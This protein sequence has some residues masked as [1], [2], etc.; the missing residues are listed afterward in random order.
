MP[1]DKFGNEIRQRTSTA[2]SDE[3]ISL[4]FANNTYIRLDGESDITGNLNMALR[5]IENLGDPTNPKD[6]TSK[7][8]V[9]NTKGTGVIGEV[10]DETATLKG[11][12]DFE[13][14]YR[15]KNLPVP[16]EQ[17]DA[18]NREYVD[19]V[20]IN[21][22]FDFVDNKYQ[23]KDDLDLQGNK[24][25]N[26]CSPF[27][28]GD[29]ATKGYLDT[30]SVAFLKVDQGIYEAKA[31]INLNNIYTV[32]NAKAPIEDGHITDKKYVDDQIKLISVFKKRN[33]GYEARNNLYMR[34][35][36][37]LGLR[38]PIQ[39]G[40]AANKQY[41]DNIYK[42]LVNQYIDDDDNLIP[43]KNVNMEGNQV[44]NLPDP[45][46]DQDAV[47]KK[48]VD[49]LQTQHV[50][51]KGNIKFGR[52]VNLDNKRI[53]A[54]KEPSKPNEGANK[55]YVDDTITKRIQEEKDNFLPQDPATKNYVDE[56]IRGIAAGDVLVSKEGVFIKE[57]GHYR[58]TAPLDID[59]QK[60]TNVAD[61]VDEKDAV[62]RK[63][64]DDTFKELTLKQG[65]IR[66]NGG[67]NLVD[68][69]I[70]MNFNNIRNLGTPKDNSDAVPRSFVENSIK[71][72]DEK[73]KKLKERIN[74]ER[75]SINMNYK[76]LLNLQKPTEKYDAA[77]KD[78]VD[79][80]VKE[81]IQFNFGELNQLVSV[82]ASC[83]EHLKIDDYPF[84]FGGPILNGKLN[85]L[86]KYNGF[87][88][89]ADGLL[90]HVSIISTGLVLNIPPNTISASSLN[91][92][93]KEI[94]KIY[95]YDAKRI[96]LFSVI[97]ISDLFADEIIGSVFVII[98]TH[99]NGG[100]AYP[101]VSDEKYDYMG[102]PS[103]E[104][105][106]NPN[107]LNNDKNFIF[108][109]KQGDIINI[110]SE[111]TET[112]ISSG[113]TFINEK[114]YYKAFPYNFLKFGKDIVNKYYLHL[115]TLTFLFKEI[116]FP[117]I[118]YLDKLGDID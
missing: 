47:N 59:N 82:S 103:F 95:A 113:E 98:P 52:N 49:D 54:M 109:V 38:E 111:Y 78:Y 80:V 14:Q 85:E 30:Q 91:E 6:A 81:K 19:E 73:I 94:N 26:L 3:G 64:I 43:G 1:V 11:N 13:D 70:N 93:L 74:E 115:A 106:P 5:K 56:A 62:N 68:S 21:H 75:P 12:L 112:I 22:P 39:D 40:E 86:D 96:K 15:I 110:K 58:A 66:E 97:R 7:E 27:E 100:R 76:R 25:K 42:N 107:Y 105:R 117:D 28:D 55:K 36:K 60:I 84:T 48:Y 32:Y 92:A 65:L 90:K 44:L 79:Y 53:F 20:A 114:G 102:S 67:F 17:K 61:P 116:T 108:P 18:V 16:V 71:T 104:F 9:D 31:D 72:V 35:N 8:Y 45:V 29:A 24:I 33:G 118:S 2:K 41:V 69:Y 51:E 34:R 83:Y 23:A 46:N 88:V 57:N 50:D 10:K 101:Y 87:L 63:Y 89:P 99:I 4:N 77:T 37:I